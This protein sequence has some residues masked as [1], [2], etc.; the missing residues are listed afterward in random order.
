MWGRSKASNISTTYITID[1]SSKLKLKQLNMRNVILR[2]T[3]M[4]PN[5]GELGY[6]LGWHLQQC[7][8]VGE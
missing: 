6:M 2:M 3:G 4:Y 7:K 5:V 1:F 8:P